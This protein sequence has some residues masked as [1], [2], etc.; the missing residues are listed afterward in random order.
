MILLL[1]GQTVTKL[2]IADLHMVPL[3]A[4]A[5]FQI[6]LLLQAKTQLQTLSNLQLLICTNNNQAEW[7]QLRLFKPNPN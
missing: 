2:L 4:E 7:M 5:D 6:L 1:E 3:I